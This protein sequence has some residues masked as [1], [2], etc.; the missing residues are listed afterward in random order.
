MYI[1]TI[2]LY[3]YLYY[4]CLCS[5][6][7][8]ICINHAL[9]L[10]VFIYLYTVVILHVFSIL[11]RYII[12][13]YL[14]LSVLFYFLCFMFSIINPPDVVRQKLHFSRPW[15]PTTLPST[16]SISSLPSWFTCARKDRVWHFRGVGIPCL[17]YQAG[18]V[19]LDLSLRSSCG[20]GPGKSIP[21]V[22]SL[23]S[24]LQTWRRGEILVRPVRVLTKSLSQ[25]TNFLRHIT[26][27]VFLPRDCGEGRNMWYCNIS[28]YCLVEFTRSRTICNLK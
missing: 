25:G 1:G 20:L 19:K 27:L 22:G 21:G 15:S 3:T 23:N 7:R 5:S 8:V 24:V 6:H 13:I 10:W 4:M 17:T 16:W 11:S 14:P 12:Y 9:S 2:S 18:P 26:V 28:H